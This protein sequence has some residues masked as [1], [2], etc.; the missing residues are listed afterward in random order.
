[1]LLNRV[2]FAMLV[3]FFVVSGAVIVWAACH[4]DTQCEIDNIESDLF[5]NKSWDIPPNNRVLY[6]ING[7]TI[8]DV[9]SL[10]TDV[11]YAASYWDRVEHN[12]QIVNFEYGIGVR[13]RKGETPLWYSLTFI[14][15]P[16]G[17][18]AA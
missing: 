7:W 15:R 8:H 18:I 10:T 6:K 17:V 9:P 14:P 5:Q 1:M 2:W 12:G 11:N 13:R 16:I 4:N 3:M